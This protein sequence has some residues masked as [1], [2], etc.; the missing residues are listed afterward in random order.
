MF[1]AWELFL[2]VITTLVAAGVL[3]PFPA[4]SKRKLGP[5]LQPTTM[6]L[7]TGLTVGSGEIAFR[8]KSFSRTTRPK[9]RRRV[10]VIGSWWH[11][12]G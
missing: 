11:L 12:D 3:A 1:L 2:E 5:K 8:S 7:F 9:R 4:S 10:S 6:S